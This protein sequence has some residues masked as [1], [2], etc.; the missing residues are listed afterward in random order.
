MVH[1]RLKKGYRQAWL[2]TGLAVLFIVGFF[3]FTWRSIPNRV[4]EWDMGGTPFV[5]ASSVYA[6]G[7]HLPANQKPTDS[8]R[9]DR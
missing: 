2:L 4:G 1:D 8:A 3:Y 5:P 7:Y 9:G 6:E